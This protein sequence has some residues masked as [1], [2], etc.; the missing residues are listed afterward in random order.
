MPKLINTISR[1]QPTSQ[2]HGCDH[3]RQKLLKSGRA[4]TLHFLPFFLTPLLNPTPPVPFPAFPIRFVSLDS[5]SSF[6]FL[7]HSLKSSWV[8][9]MV[10]SPANTFWRILRSVNNRFG[11]LLYNAM[12]KLKQ[13]LLPKCLQLIFFILELQKVVGQAIWFAH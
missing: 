4:K 8:W 2:F 9:G 11:S 7:L 10:S 13:I 5:F 3:R 6:P 1:D 12:I